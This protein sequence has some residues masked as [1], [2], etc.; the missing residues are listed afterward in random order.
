MKHIGP[1]TFALGI[2]HAA[3]RPERVKTLAALLAGLGLAQIKQRWIGETGAQAA[4]NGLTTVKVFDRKCPYWEWASEMWHWQLETCAS[5]C[6]TLQD[7]VRAMP[8]FWEALH[9]MVSAV[10]DQ[11]LALETVHPAARHY[12]RE[13]LGRWITS[14]DGLIGVQYVI[15]RFVM[16]EFLDW[17]A[18]ELRRDAECYVTEDA[19]IDCFL[20]DTGRKAWHPIPAIAEH[21]TDIPS[22]NAGHDAHPFR[23]VSVRWSDGVYCTKPM[24]GSP[25]W[26][27][28]DLARP[29]FWSSESEPQHIGR[30]YS[31][32]HSV[33]LQWVKSFTQEKWSRVEND[34]PPAK[35]AKEMGGL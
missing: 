5:H 1:I 14:A 13:H 35:F 7:D 27:V 30:F 33:A 19:L 21:D 16:K 4:M 32:T 25:G 18:R 26:T 12:A 8:R 31:R 20:I 22:T 28:D 6:L 9:A 2:P 23:N 29:E 17:K 15:P 10:P 24:D 34:K 3:H 11:V